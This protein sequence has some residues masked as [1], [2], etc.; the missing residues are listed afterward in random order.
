MNIIIRD[1]STKGYGRVVEYYQ[2]TTYEQIPQEVKDTLKDTYYEIE[3]TNDCYTKKYDRW[4]ITE[5]E[6]EE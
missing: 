1:T 2:N 5:C 3:E 4:W 6:C